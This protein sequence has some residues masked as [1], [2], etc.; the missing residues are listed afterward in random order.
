MC[1]IL[2]EINFDGQK[3]SPDNFLKILSLSSRRGPDYVGIFNEI[4]NIQ[5]GF[6]RLSILDLSANAHQPI[7]SND[8]KYLMVFNGEIYNYIDIKNK[9]EQLGVEIKSSGDTE[10]LVNSFSKLGIDQTV[11][12][13][14][15]MYSERMM[16]AG[17][18]VRPSGRTVINI[19]LRT[20]VRHRVGG[21]LRNDSAQLAS[22]DYG[23][24]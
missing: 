18:V 10:V 23:G 8:Q 20:I 2:G 15:G 14:D 7:F 1:G 5:F 13:L 21:I 3:T 16:R 11:K 6:N 12:M 9:L 24:C 19:R 22:T 17:A 4:E